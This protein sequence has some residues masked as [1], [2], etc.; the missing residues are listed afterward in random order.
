MIKISA[1]F[2]NKNSLCV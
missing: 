2:F 1:L